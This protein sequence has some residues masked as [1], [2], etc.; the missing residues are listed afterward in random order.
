MVCIMQPLPTALAQ[1]LIAITGRSATGYPTH[2]PC[3]L[4]VTPCPQNLAN[5]RLR[6]ARVPRSL[7]SPPFSHHNEQVSVSMLT[8]YLHSQPFRCLRYTW[9]ASL[10]ISWAVFCN[11]DCRPGCLFGVVF[12]EDYVWCCTLDRLKIPEL[13]R[14]C[15]PFFSFPR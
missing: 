6:P 1:V 3:L 4:N 7:N 10:A 8:T 14:V 11:R 9:Q 2:K 13:V 12:C 15:V 5:P